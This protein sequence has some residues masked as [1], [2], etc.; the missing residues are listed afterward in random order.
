MGLREILGYK[1]DRQ[2][3]KE[4]Q[5]CT[6]FEMVHTAGCFVNGRNQHMFKLVGNSRSYI[7]LT[8]RRRARPPC[9]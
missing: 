3:D 8:S 2:E 9:K 4:S 7:S 1:I 5:F 6:T